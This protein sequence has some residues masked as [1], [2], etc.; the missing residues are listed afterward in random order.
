MV[1]SALLCGVSAVG[2]L[3]GC[4]SSATEDLMKVTFAPYSTP[5]TVDT[6]CENSGCADW[7]RVAVTVEFDSDSYVAEDTQVDLEQYR[8]E[9]DLSDIEDEVPY[10]ASPL[11]VSV[12]PDETTTFYVYVAGQTQRD[13]V[14]KAAGG[15]PVHGLALLTLAGYDQQDEQV[16]LEKGFDIEFADYLETGDGGEADGG[17]E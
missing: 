4:S 11:E 9:Y 12:V 8:I 14:R 1:K 10:F 17:A 7:N 6:S 5:V 16:F 15:K 13:F 2:L 3:W